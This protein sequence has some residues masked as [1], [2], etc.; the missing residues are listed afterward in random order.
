MSMQLRMHYFGS[1]A[2]YLP[3]LVLS[4]R[5]VRVKPHFE[6]RAYLCTSLLLLLAYV[7]QIKHVLVA[8]YPIAGDAWFGRLHPIFPTLRK[9]CAEDP[10]IVLADTNAGH[11]VRYYSDCS[12]IANNFLLTEQHFRKVEEMM[13]LF[14][15]QPSELIEQA[16]HVKYVL[17]RPGNIIPK[18]NGEVQYAFW[19]DTAPALG[20]QLLLGPLAATPPHFRL[21]GSVDL[22]LSGSMQVMPYARLYKVEASDPGVTK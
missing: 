22:E 19:G 21:I 14:T 4:Q 5:L 15:L 3:Y 1:Y 18:E 13:H 2:L 12:V 10:G 8:P 16:P 11:Y 20:R 6:R 17:V 7:P 9:A